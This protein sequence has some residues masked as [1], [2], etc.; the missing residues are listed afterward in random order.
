MEE[1]YFILN[2]DIKKY[3]MRDM[4]GIK[5]EKLKSII[6]PPMSR[7]FIKVDNTNPLFY[8]N[9]LN[10]KNPINMDSTGIYHKINNIVFEKLN[11]IKF[12]KVDTINV[13]KL[14]QYELINMK[15]KLSNNKIIYLYKLKDLNSKNNFYYLNS[16]DIVK[17]VKFTNKPFY[18]LNNN[19]NIVTNYNLAYTNKDGETMIIDNKNIQIFEMPETFYNINKKEFIVILISFFII[20]IIFIIILYYK[21]FNRVNKNK[22]FFTSNKWN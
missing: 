8:T 3:S 20:F 16:N 15:N 6:M 11:T 22:T 7:I 14:I 2:G 18:S 17:N 9:F 19:G 4:I 10:E 1:P 5:Q 13:N 12:E 21:K